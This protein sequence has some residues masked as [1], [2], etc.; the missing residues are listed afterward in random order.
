MRGLI[1]GTLRGLGYRY[2]VVDCQYERRVTRQPAQPG[3]L[4]APDNKPQTWLDNG[5]RCFTES[6]ITCAKIL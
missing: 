6:V 1:V 4:L 2:S 3:F 5:M